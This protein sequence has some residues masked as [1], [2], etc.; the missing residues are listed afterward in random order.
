MHGLRIVTAVAALA[1]ADIPAFAQGVAPG[2]GI[3]GSTGI[4]SGLGGGVGTGPSWPNGTNQAPEPS[5]SSVPPGGY[6][7]PAPSFVSPPA[8]QPSPYPQPRDPFAAA[9]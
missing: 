6:D 9:E 4:G 5:I 2:G 8:V 1:L 3:G 7:H